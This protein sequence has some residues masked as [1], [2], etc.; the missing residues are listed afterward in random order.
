[1]L[2]I[3]LGKRKNFEEQFDNS[4]SGWAELLLAGSKLVISLIDML[5]TSNLS[6]EL[7]P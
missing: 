3:L 2:D 5:K 1:M 7:V 6:T 4:L